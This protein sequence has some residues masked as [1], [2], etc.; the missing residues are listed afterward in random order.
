MQSVAEALSLALTVP[1]LVLF[2]V[3]VGHWWPRA[4]GKR[5]AVGWV[6]LGIVL[7]FGGQFFDNLYWGFAWASE[8]INHPSKD[9]L[10]LHGVYSNIPFRQLAGMLAAY[11]H[12]RGFFIMLGQ[13][14]RIKRLNL[15]TLQS[16]VAG[17]I[18]VI[19]LAN[20]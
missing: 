4:R 18:I 20:I 14:G 16:L 5:D 3:T 12:C 13:R 10:F 1:A 2:A 17:V 19:A 15:I 8:F 7:S 6:A 9:F 11:C